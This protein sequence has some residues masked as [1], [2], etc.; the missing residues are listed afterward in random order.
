MR[1][2]AGTGHQ[3][4]SSLPPRNI[5]RGTASWDDAKP[6]W[7]VVVARIF[8]SFSQVLDVL[9]VDMKTVP[10]QLAGVFIPGG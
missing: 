8:A 5:V 3:C 9:V 6:L 7:L 2:L 10:I 1:T 4:K